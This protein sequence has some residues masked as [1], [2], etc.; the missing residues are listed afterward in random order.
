MYSK[1]RNNLRIMMA[2]SP[3][4]LYMPGLDSILTVSV[5]LFVFY[6]EL[7]QHSSYKQPEIWSAGSQTGGNSEGE[8]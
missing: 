3:R 1:H 5:G 4:T 2:G 8:T 7:I 6:I